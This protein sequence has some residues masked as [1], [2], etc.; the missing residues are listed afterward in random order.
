ML[1]KCI[2]MYTCIDLHYINEW[3]IIIV[4]PTFILTTD[5]RRLNRVFKFVKSN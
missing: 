2:E 1:L 3:I 5:I 4:R